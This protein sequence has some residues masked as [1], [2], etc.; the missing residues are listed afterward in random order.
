MGC[1]RRESRVDLLRVVAVEEGDR[2]VAVP[3]V[4]SR[5]PGRGAWLHRCP[6]C[7]DLAER[8]LAFTRALRLRGPLDLALLRR[9]IT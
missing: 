3:D 9:V 4:R 7:L 6:G 5:L 2:L 8:R 1:R